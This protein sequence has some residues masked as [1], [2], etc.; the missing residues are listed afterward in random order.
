MTAEPQA[1]KWIEA[2]CAVCLVGITGYY[3]GVAKHQNEA[4]QMVLVQSNDV[5]EQ[6]PSAAANPALSNTVLPR[7]PDCSLRG[8]DLGSN[9]GW[10]F[11]SILC[12]VINRS[13]RG[14]LLEN[15]ALRQQL[16]VFKPKRAKLRLSFL[17]KLA[18]FS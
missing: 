1:P 7:A 8:D 17:D 16:I 13:H 11:Q 3:A 14:L 5:V 4:I 9:R 12:I 10:N 2:I 6:I 18:S 15:L